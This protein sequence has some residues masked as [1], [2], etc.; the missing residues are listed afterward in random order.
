[1]LTSRRVSAKSKEWRLDL[2]SAKVAAREKE[3]FE[4]SEQL[5]E[6]LQLIFAVLYVLSI[7]TII[8]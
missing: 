3:A 7:R 6:M 8:E 5:F 4:I 1:M 2:R